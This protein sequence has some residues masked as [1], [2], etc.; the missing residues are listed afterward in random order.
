VTYRVFGEYRVPTVPCL[1]LN[2]GW[3]FTGKR[4]VNNANQAYIDGGGTL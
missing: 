2:A 1:A 3:Y 4:L